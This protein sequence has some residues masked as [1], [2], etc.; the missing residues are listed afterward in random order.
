MNSTQKKVLAIT[1]VGS[2]ALLAKYLSFS[3]TARPEQ[4]DW[5]SLA[6]LVA[7]VGVAAVVWTGRK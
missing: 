4:E 2:G 7:A 6:I 3:A 5:L 1:V